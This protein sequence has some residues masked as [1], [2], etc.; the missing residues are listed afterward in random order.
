MKCGL[1]TV[2]LYLHLCNI[3]YSYFAFLHKWRALTNFTTFKGESYHTRHST[4][5]LVHTRQPWI[6]CLFDCCYVSNRI[7][8]S[9]NKKWKINNQYLHFLAICGLCI[10]FDLPLVLCLDVAVGSDGCCCLVSSDQFITGNARPPETA[11]SPHLRRPEPERREASQ[12]A[13]KLSSSGSGPKQ[14]LH[15]SQSAQIQNKS[16]VLVIIQRKTELNK[17]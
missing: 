1:K 3:V 12:S 11:C 4:Q 5:Y 8:W 2:N 13:G 17:L 6:L 7:S 14:S 10:E 15:D 16:K 9:S